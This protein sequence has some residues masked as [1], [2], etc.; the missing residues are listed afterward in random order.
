MQFSQGEI[1]TLTAQFMSYHQKLPPKLR[2]ILGS[3]AF[4]YF[5]V[6]EKLILRLSNPFL[7]IQWQIH[8]RLF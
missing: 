8:F 5:L 2:H 6:V 4:S 7:K 1:C 3:L